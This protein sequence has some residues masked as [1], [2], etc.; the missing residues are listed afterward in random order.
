MSS[1][2]SAI[3]QHGQ[4]RHLQK[5]SG[6]TIFC[7]GTKAFTSGLSPWAIFT[8]S[9]SKDKAWVIRGLKNSQL[10]VLSLIFSVD[11]PS[12]MS[13]VLP[14]WKRYPLIYPNIFFEIRPLQCS[15]F[16]LITCSRH[17]TLQKFEFQFSKSL[18]LFIEGGQ[19]NIFYWLK[20]FFGP[21]KNVFLSPF[22]K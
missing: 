21:M 3:G 10:C 12:E 6:R 19:E 16:C 13:N 11:H 5:H 7:L 18:F 22:N 4:P 17:R 9:S 8:W 15:Y 2:L 14:A 20:I 1:K